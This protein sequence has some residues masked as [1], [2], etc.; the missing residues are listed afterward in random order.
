MLQFCSVNIFCESVP[1]FMSYTP[2]V[3]TMS[4]NNSSNLRLTG[5]LGYN[6]TRPTLHTAPSIP[7]EN[8]I[9]NAGTDVRLNCSKNHLT[10][11]QGRVAWIRHQS[12]KEN[13]SAGGMIPKP[14]PTDP[15]DGSI[16]LTNL[17]AIRDEGIYTCIVA[18]RKL[19]KI[20]LIVKS[21]PSAVMN[22]S[23]IPHSVYALVTWNMSKRGD[24]GYPILRYVLSY[25]LERSHLNM[26]GENY[27]DWFHGELDSMEGTSSHLYSEENYL[28]IPNDEYQWRGK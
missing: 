2:Q 7:I 10:S 18:D 25:K 23:V 5:D 27:S 3:P 16:M 26:T 20:R 19:K 4:S 9:A 6:V 21:T 15:E 24:G 8:V 14:F 28:T 1:T 11:S 12:A 22:L 13:H 17:S